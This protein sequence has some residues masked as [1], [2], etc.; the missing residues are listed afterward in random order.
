MV[1]SATFFPFC[2]ILLISFFLKS[3]PVLYSIEIVAQWLLYGDVQVLPPGG[4]VLS[5]VQ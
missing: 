2:N 3:L 5:V 1:K 4:S